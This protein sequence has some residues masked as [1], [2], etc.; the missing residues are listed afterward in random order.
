MEEIRLAIGKDNIGDMFGLSEEEIIEISDFIQS[1][2]EAKRSWKYVIESICNSLNYT[3]REKVLM[4]MVVGS[5]MERSRTKEA[6]R[7][8]QLKQR[9]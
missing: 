8:I 6:I 9:I 2:K 3:D 5:Q 7:K 4:L 1:L